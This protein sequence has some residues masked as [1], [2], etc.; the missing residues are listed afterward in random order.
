M[1]DSC[2]ECGGDDFDGIDDI[3]GDMGAVGFGA[4]SED[5]VTSDEDV[6]VTS[7]E[8]VVVTSDEDV[9]VTSDDNV[10]ITS[11]IFVIVAVA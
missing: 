2:G 10:I 6:V 4:G 1:N 3:T 7:D 5:V 9:V 11:G 8:D